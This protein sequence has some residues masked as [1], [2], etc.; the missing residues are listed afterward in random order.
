MSDEQDATGIPAVIQANLPGYLLLRDDA[1]MAE[2][3]REWLLSL[4]VDRETG[5]FYDDW[6]DLLAKLNAYV[7][8]GE[9]PQATPAPG[10]LTAFKGGKD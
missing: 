8:R 10:K 6:E 3:R 4:V 7:E 2:G 1:R 5:H 9:L